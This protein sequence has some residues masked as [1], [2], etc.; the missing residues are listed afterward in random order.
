MIYQNHKRRNGG[1]T[2]IGDLNKNHNG[3]GEGKPNIYLPG[4]EKSEKR[5]IVINHQIL[6][7]PPPELLGKEG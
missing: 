7:F 2:S 5:E 6:S 1:I 3:R 4:D